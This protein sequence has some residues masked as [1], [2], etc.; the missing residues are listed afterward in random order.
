VN[1]ISRWILECFF[2]V[3]FEVDFGMFFWVDFIMQSLDRCRPC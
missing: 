3:D 1:A 2:E